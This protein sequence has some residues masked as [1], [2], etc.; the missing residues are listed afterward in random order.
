MGSGDG[1]QVENK[2]WA[3]ID[4]LWQH[5]NKENWGLN[6]TNCSAQYS[7]E[8]PKM[9]HSTGVQCAPFEDLELIESGW[10]FC[11]FLVYRNWTFS[12]LQIF[13]VG[14]FWEREQIKSDYWIFWNRS[15]PIFVYLAYSDIMDLE[16]SLFRLLECKNSI[17]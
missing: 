15:E 2:R 6:L 10:D 4:I 5:I 11:D 1:K 3:K 9:M 14:I 8:D 7:I 13:L 12:A 16:N 17:F